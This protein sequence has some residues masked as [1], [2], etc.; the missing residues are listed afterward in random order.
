VKQ[1]QNECTAVNMSK[2]CKKNNWTQKTSPATAQPNPW[3][4]ICMWPFMWKHDVIHKTRVHNILHCCYIALSE[5]R[6]TD[7]YRRF[8]ACGFTDTEWTDRYAYIH[9]HMLIA[10][11]Y[12]T[13]MTVQ[14]NKRSMPKF[15]R[16]MRWL[17]INSFAFT[18]L[19]ITFTV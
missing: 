12:T 4:V 6:A 11:L 7:M 5:D 2:I 16:G 3:L 8:C 18:V 13:V 19:L 14:N 9:W 17:R 1:A 15:L 10:M